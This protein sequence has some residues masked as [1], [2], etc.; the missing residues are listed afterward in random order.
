MAGS[1]DPGAL[2]RDTDQFQV[3]DVR[4][5]NEWEAG[6]IQGARHIP[7]DY[8]LDRLEELDR[9]R[10]V[11]TVC[12]SGDRSAEAAKELRGEG[13]DVRN[14]EGGMQAW[15]A[16]R[17]P[18]VASDGTPGTVA[19]PEPPPD[20]RPEAMQ[21]LQ[22]DFLEVVFAAQEHFG[23]KEPTDEEMKGFLRQRMIDEGKS[24][25][26]ADRSLAAMDAPSQ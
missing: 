3:V 24:P 9:T 22:A 17:L 6:H 2:A 15:A 13:F 25:E 16:Q 18:F 26:E 5:P 21:Q 20:D 12:R 4:Y 10:P 7:V 1:I 14:L 23:D 8:V 19:D 11:V